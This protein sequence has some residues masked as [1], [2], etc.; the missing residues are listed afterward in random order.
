MPADLVEARHWFERAA[1]AGLTE[2][3]A[4]LAE[5]QVNGRGGPAAPDAARHWFETAAKA[6]HTGAMFALGAL[7]AG[8]HGLPE[9][10]AA[11]QH[12][13]TE[14][15]ERGH[16]YA[17]LMLARCLASSAASPPNETG[18]PPLTHS[19][20]QPVSGKRRWIEPPPGGWRNTN[21]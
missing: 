9:N 21:I 19:R 12:W 7:H 15:A 4:A 13:W 5:M 20:R 17:Q 11:A 3:Q 18:R 16:G 14:A 10:P 2:A 1:E 6:G 8:G